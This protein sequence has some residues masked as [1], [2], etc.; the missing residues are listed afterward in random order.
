MAHYEIE[1]AA[2]YVIVGTGAGGATAGRVLAGAGLDVLFLEEGSELPRERPRDLLSSMSTAVRDMGSQTTSGSCPIP[3]LQG[4][5]VGG[6]TVINSGIIW[7]LPEDVRDDWTVRF[8]LGRLVDSLDPIFETIEDELEV[9]ET[10]EEV[11]GGNAKRMARACEVLG[12]PGK[13]IARNARRCRGSARCLQGCPNQARQSMDVSYI[14]RARRDGARLRTNVRVERVHMERSHTG[15]RRV[16]GVSGRVIDPRR[17]SARGR[18]FIRA[19]RAVIVSAGVIH[20]P[21]ILAKSGLGGRHV[22]RHFQAH[23][24]LAVVGRFPEPIG[25]GYG[26]TQAYE[27]PMRERGFKLEALSLPPEM[28]AARIPGAGRSWQSRLGELDHYAQWAVQCRFKA[29]G[30]VKPGLFGPSVHYEPLDRDLA[31]IQSAAALLCRMMFAAGATEVYAGLGKLPEVLRD[32]RDVEPLDRLVLRRKDIHMVASH[33]FGTARACADPSR[34][35]VDANLEV[36]GAPGVFVMDASVFPTNLGV[37]PQHSIMGVVWRAAE[38]LANA[39]TGR[40]AA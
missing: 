38:E 4:R 25:M 29:E 36:H 10:S 35:V 40:R 6:S 1:D 33:L 39:Q 8:G 15:Q 37:N 28:L 20:T 22:G 31:V 24:G 12:L 21:V 34:G 11:L 5:A 23:P 18:F 19:R 2:D 16:L 26:A 9:D 7:R 32:A 14:P 3:L 30:T 27:V 17:G 13:P